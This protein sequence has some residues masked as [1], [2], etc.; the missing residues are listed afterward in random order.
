MTAEHSAEILDT[1]EMLRSYLAAQLKTT[2]EADQDLFDSG[3]VNSMFAMELVVH[4]EQTFQIAVLGAD[5]RLDN[6]RSVRSMAT[7]VRRLRD[8]RGR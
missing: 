2:V 5:L 8:D 4:L 3:L 6:F 1:E 7:L